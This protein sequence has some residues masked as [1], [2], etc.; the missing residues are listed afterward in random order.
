M[1][2]ACT[3]CT[4]ALSVATTTKFQVSRTRLQRRSTALGRALKDS[5]YVMFTDDHAAVA[6]SLSRLL[7]WPAG[8]LDAG[9]VGDCLPVATA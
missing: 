8:R 6:A 5:G 1:S 2:D 4:A 7:D 9:R 3:G